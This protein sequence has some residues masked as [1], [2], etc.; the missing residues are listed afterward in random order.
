VRNVFDFSAENA[1]IVDWMADEAVWCEL[2]SVSNSLI[3]R[4]NTGNFRDF[5]VLE[6][7]RRRKT[8]VFSEIFL[9]IP[10]LTKQGI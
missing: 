9:R 2:L 6:P 4:E 10:Y 7:P 3:I 1:K 8:L 5:G